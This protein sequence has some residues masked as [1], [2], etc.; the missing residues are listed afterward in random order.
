MQNPSNLPAKSDRAA[1]LAAAKARNAAKQAA[2]P[3][4]TDATAAE[5]TRAARLIKRAETCLARAATHFGEISDRDDAYTALFGAIARCI[6]S[7]TIR[8]A[9][10][11]A[12][13]PRDAS[14]KPIN[15]IYSGPSRNAADGGVLNRLCNAG[16]FTRSPDG[17]SL[18]V[19]SAGKALAVYSAYAI[20]DRKLSANKAA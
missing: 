6:K 8:I 17:K 11:L 14:G 1:K 9:D 15:P 12:H 20:A 5:L 3:V 18:T 4:A 16:R 10:I 19:T 7:D 2:K 13:A